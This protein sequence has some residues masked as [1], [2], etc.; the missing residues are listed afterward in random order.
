MAGVLMGLG[1]LRFEMAKTAYEELA[2]KAEARW[3][4]QERIGRAPALQFVGPGADTIELNGTVYPGQI[5][6]ADTVDRMRELATEGEAMML[7]SGTG[8]VFGRFVIARAEHTGSHFDERGGARRLEFRL[9]VRA[10]GEDG[11]GSS[12]L[13]RLYR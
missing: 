8:R 11:K 4:A 10:Y 9:E 7:V 12:S 13:W 5:G 6:S 2:R 1:P 3:P